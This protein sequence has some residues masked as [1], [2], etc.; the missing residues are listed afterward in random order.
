MIKEIGPNINPIG[1]QLLKASMREDA[2]AQ[3]FAILSIGYTLCKDKFL[4]QLNKEFKAELTKTPD[5]RDPPD[6]PMTIELSKPDPQGQPDPVPIYPAV[7]D[8]WADIIDWVMDPGKISTHSTTIGR[9]LLRRVNSST[10]KL[11]P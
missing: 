6:Q 9:F 10:A 1:W 2:D 7:V 8:F 11:V 3:H 4:D 5:Q